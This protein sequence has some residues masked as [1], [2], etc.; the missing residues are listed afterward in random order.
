MEDDVVLACHKME[1][2]LQEKEQTEE[3]IR[4]N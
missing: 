4:K 2:M 3:E 1:N